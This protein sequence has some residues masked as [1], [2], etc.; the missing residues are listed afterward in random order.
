M[1]YII[2]GIVAG[3]LSFIVNVKAQ[4]GIKTETRTYMKT[5]LCASHTDLVNNLNTEHKEARK[6]WA[7]N[8][9]NELITDLLLGLVQNQRNWGF[10][11]CFL[12]L[13]NVKGYDWN[14][15]RVYRIYREL[16][17]NIRIKPNKTFKA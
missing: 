14:H 13:R 17:L 7:V 6:W 9:D 10:G 11:L 2:I 12:Y 3:L 1:K 16:E 5:L 15:K 4:E 8:S